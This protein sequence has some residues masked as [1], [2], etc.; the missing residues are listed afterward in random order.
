MIEK[1]NRRELL[2]VGCADGNSNMAQ[3]KP[4]SELVPSG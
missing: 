4:P 3:A 2:R 1:I